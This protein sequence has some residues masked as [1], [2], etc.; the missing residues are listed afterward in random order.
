MTN[1]E[2]VC[3]EAERASAAPFAQRR[4]WA[5]RLG[6]EPLT[7]VILHSSFARHSDFGLRH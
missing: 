7:F 3:G 4:R 1:D 6:H 5:I 2:N